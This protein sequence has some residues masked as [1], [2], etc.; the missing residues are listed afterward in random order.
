M[1]PAGWGLGSRQEQDREARR[2]LPGPEP[3]T[4]AF[5]PSPFGYGDGPAPP[6]PRFLGQLGLTGSPGDGTQLPDGQ[7]EG[8]HLLVCSGSWLTSCP[9]SS[10]HKATTGMPLTSGGSQS[11]GSVTQVTRQLQ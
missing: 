8:G 4:P 10:Q 6:P 7:K 5:L 3:Q 11:G 1:C 9:A 2:G